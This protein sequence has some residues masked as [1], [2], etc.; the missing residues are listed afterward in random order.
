MPE[1]A[2]VETVIRYSDGSEEKLTLKLDVPALA[3]AGLQAIVLERIQEWFL[4]NGGTVEESVY[5]HIG[6]DEWETCE[7]KR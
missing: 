5:P 1:I 2:V 6:E 3:S 7:T 4:R